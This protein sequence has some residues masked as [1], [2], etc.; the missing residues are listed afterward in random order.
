MK[1]KVINDV[2]VGIDLGTTYSCCHYYDIQQKKYET[3]KYLDG[4]STI[5]SIV[6]FDQQPVLVGHPSQ[7]AICEVKR[8]IGMK[9][10][11]PKVQDL[12][13]RNTWPFEIVPGEDGYAAVQM[14]ST[15]SGKEEIMMPEMVSA[16]VLKEI[17]IEL[18]RNLGISPDQTVE[19][20]VT[21]PAY[22]NDEQKDRTKRAALM[23]GFNLRRILSEPS[24]AVYAYGMEKAK[25]GFYLA[26]D[27]GGG[28]FD[29]TILKKENNG[30]N[31]HFVVMDGDTHL[32]GIDFDLNF[33]E[34]LLEKV[35]ED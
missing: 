29:V 20:I 22:F 4:K 27:L 23:S 2:V 24:S 1:T 14:Y 12:I 35:K 8:L 19:A 10:D 9:F 11:D 25:D 18:Q 26:F 33:M 13:N 32:G 3:L 7:F 5:A 17:H 34:V 30:E 28:T 16:I 15:L 6:N 21:V 31:M